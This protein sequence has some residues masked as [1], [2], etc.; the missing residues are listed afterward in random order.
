MKLNLKRLQRL[1]QQ[2]ME[3]RKAVSYTHLLQH[4][5][6]ED[7]VIATGEYHTVREFTTL[8]FKETGVNLCW[9]GDVYK[10]QIQYKSYRTSLFRRMGT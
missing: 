8:A 9:E 6:P 7:F 1:L 2:I 3:F 4:D 5:V 10:R